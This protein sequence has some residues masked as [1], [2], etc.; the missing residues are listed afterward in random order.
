MS[1]YSRPSVVLFGDSITQYSFCREQR[2]WGAGL[3]DWYQRSADVFNRGFGGYN[4]S[5]GLCVVKKH[6]LMPNLK[7]A[8]ICFGANDSVAKGDAE[9]NMHVSVPHYRSNMA[10]IVLAFRDHDPSMRMI[11]ITP[12]PVDSEKWPNRHSTR[13]AAYAQA[14]REVG[15]AMEVKVL[16]LWQTG[17]HASGIVAEAITTADLSDGIHLGP[18]GNEKVYTGL[19]ALISTSFP[20]LVPADP[21]TPTVTPPSLPICPSHATPSITASSGAPPPLPS[22]CQGLPLHLPRWSTLQEGGD[23]DYSRILTDWGES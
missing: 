15:E 23:Q 7:L 9:E 19:R 18:S 6:V 20:E 1:S 3:A 17:E 2:G 10:S 5:Y 16:D 13:T 8:I 11:L 4:S 14:T 21:C 22:R 12:P